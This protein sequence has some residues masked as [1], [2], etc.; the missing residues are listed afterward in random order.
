[1][2]GRESLRGYLVQTMSALLGALD[3]NAWEA[4]SLEPVHESEKVDVKWRYPDHIKVVQIKSSQNAFKQH[5]IKLWCKEL[6]SS[7]QADQYELQL[8]GTI[9]AATNDLL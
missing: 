3:D 9:A 6:T 7:T 8:V 5:Q 4:V 2:G 1:M